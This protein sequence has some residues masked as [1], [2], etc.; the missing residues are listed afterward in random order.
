MDTEFGS[1]NVVIPPRVVVLAG[2]GPVRVVWKNEVGG[3]TCEYGQGDARRFVKWSPPD[4]VDLA[5]EA[6]RL[7]WAGQYVRVPVVVDV[8]SD[9]DGTWMVT[10]PVTGEN[11]VTKR[12]VAD[13]ATATRAIGEGLRALHEALPV[14]SCPF[15][16][17]AAE[18]V[19]DAQRRA[20]SGQIDR[21]EWEETHRPIDL[22]AALAIVSD[23][24]D[25][26]QI[27]VC[28][29]DTCAPNTLIDDSGRWSGH[30]DFGTMGIAD[31]WADLAIA[32]LSATWNYGPEWEEPV[33]DAYGIEPDLRRI[34]YYRL[35]WDL[36]P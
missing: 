28:H 7:E 32:T 13:P 10:L 19:A 16:W 27:V 2:G 31:R 6:V 17:N 12:W 24:P 9:S 23:I 11:A 15:S 4:A 20:E 36:D 26:D 18:R 25:V 22:P 1:A 35:L 34:P 5:G 29:G 21:R 3:V 30:V 33:L 14:A 8:G